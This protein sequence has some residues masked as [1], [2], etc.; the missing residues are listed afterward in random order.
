MHI[1]PSFNI[2][3]IIGQMY[4][5][6]HQVLLMSKMG[7]GLEKRNKNPFLDIKLTMNI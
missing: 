7:K 2:S 6:N 4:E 1:M 3:V 5:R